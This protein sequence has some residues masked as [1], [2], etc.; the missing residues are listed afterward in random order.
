MPYPLFFWKIVLIPGLW[1][2]LASWS[3]VAGYVPP[4]TTRQIQELG[5]H[6]ADTSRKEKEDRP[7]TFLIL[8]VI[9]FS[10][11]TSLRLGAI[12]I[13]FFGEKIRHQ[14]RNFLPSNFRSTIP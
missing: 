13:Y 10:P 5:Y 9:S 6:P 2:L 8:P 4:D 14:V 1:C 11:E 12:G 3:A 7:G